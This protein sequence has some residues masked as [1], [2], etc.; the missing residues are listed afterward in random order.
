[1]YGLGRIHAPDTRDLQFLID[2]PASTRTSRF[3][4][5]YGTYLDQGQTPQC[6]A[7][8]WM[9]FYCDSPKAH[10]LPFEPPALFYAE[11]QKIDG[12][13]MPHDGSSVRAGAQRMKADGHCTS[14]QWAFDLQTVVNCILEQGPV[15]VGTNW[16]ESMFKPVNGFLKISP[17]SDLAGGHAYK[18]DGVNVTKR[19]VRMKNSWGT[20]WG[21]HGYARMSFD[22]LERLIS[23]DGEACKAVE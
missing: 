10:A 19:F 18:L 23:E 13:P 3:W 9:H 8:A 11:E 7:Y 6:T 1:M 2:A 20:Q 16:Y 17:G 12:F 22:T 15:V 21:N 14:Y 5:G 4:W